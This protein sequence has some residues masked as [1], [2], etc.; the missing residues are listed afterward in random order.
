MDV[1]D[2][3]VT[4]EDM[5][6]LGERK[7]PLLKPEDNAP[8]R[9]G[10]SEEIRREADLRANETRHAD[11]VR[12]ADVHRPGNGTTTEPHHETRPMNGEEKLSPL[13]AGNE[14]HDMRGR[15]ERIQAGF[16]DEPRKAVEQADELVAETMQRLAQ[17][18]AEQKKNLETQWAR[19]DKISTEDLRM[20]FR[21]YRSFFD[22]LLS[23]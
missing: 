2:R 15:W 18:F 1:R 3:R 11:E 9:D 22:R 7:R 5:A 6:A 12:E 16:V 13:L 4:T 10:R 21:R 14:E 23:L 17:S 8:N 20:A 19:S